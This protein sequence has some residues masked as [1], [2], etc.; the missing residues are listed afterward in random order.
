MNWLKK[1]LRINQENYTDYSNV[2][3]RADAISR[4]VVDRLLQT[5]CESYLMMDVAK[6]ASSLS[7]SATIKFSHISGE[8][9]RESSGGKAMLLNYLEVYKNGKAKFLEYEMKVKDVLSEEPQKWRINC[10]VNYVAVHPGVEVMKV[11]T[12]QGL[13]IELESGR[14]VVTEAH[15]VQT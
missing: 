1:I 10:D 8:T 12:K 2:G 15:I 3:I 9:S 11:R 7:E 14:A 13:T 5:I 6:L 4:D